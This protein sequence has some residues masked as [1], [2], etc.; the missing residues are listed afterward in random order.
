MKSK[1]IF[2]VLWVILLVGCA[3]TNPPGWVAKQTSPSIGCSPENITISNYEANFMQ[4]TW[5]AVCNGKLF[6]CVWRDNTN[7]HCTETMK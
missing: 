5:K 1:Q 7:T 3:T 6:Y 4:P 2:W